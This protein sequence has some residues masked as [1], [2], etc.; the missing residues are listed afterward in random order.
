M[1]T[2]GITGGHESVTFPHNNF[3]IWL[4]V[5]QIPV[6]KNILPE[7]TIKINKNGIKNANVLTVANNK[8]PH[9]E[10]NRGPDNWG[11]GS[12]DP[13]TYLTIRIKKK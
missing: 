2:C 13:T 10:T 9:E 4:M 12:K 5:F 11:L 3:E 1:V 7:L 8:E 6:K